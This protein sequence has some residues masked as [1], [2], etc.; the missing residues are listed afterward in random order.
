M[1]N[2]RKSTP[3]YLPHK[4]SGR[5]RAVWTD[6]LGIRQQK[7]LP[8]PFGSP[9]SRTA[10]AKL[11]LELAAAPFQSLSTT[12]ATISV[13]EVLLAHLN[14]AEGHYRRADGSM[15]HEVDAYRLICRYVRELY[16][17][18][19]AADFGPLAL[20][21]VRQKFIAVGWCRSL[22][23]QRVKR[24]FKWA[25]SEQLI[26]VTV[27]EGLAT[28]PGLQRGRSQVRPGHGR[29][30]VGIPPAAP[31]DG[32]AGEGS[33]RGRQPKAREL[34]RRF[35]PA[36]PAAPLFSPAAAVAEYHAER[37]ASRETPRYPS[38][39]TR[40]VT[41]R[42]K[43]P[44]RAPATVYSVSSYGQAIDRACDKAFPPPA[45]LARREDETEAEWWARLSD[46]EKREVETWR[47][48]HRWHPNQLRHTFAT[49]VRKG[50]GL[51]A[52]QCYSAMPKPT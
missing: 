10:F 24:V 26:P 22:I 18:I 16:G 5:G 32:V 50:H 40:N 1:S 41:K 42:K 8:G 21:A 14:H 12:P 29:G 49:T 15:T 33:R 36:A 51:E 48:A 35:Q 11:H 45:P 9:E 46:E 30:G 17:A 39:M 38:H 34:L 3:S 19:P 28:V 7:L 52:A 47:K 13:N 4:Q 20:K 25:A 31:Q 6:A 43:A 44:K 27:F 23:N 2:R 37:G